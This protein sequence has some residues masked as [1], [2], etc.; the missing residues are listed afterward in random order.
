M[1]N[2]NLFRKLNNFSTGFSIV[3]IVGFIFTFVSHFYSL[4]QGTTFI[5][6]IVDANFYS[7]IAFFIMLFFIIVW[8]AYRTFLF[9][10]SRI[11]PDIKIEKL[12]IGNRAF[13]TI[14]NNETVAIENISVKIAD[15]RYNN[16]PNDVE[17]FSKSKSFSTGLTDIGRKIIPN[18]SPINVLIAQGLSFKYTE[19]FIDD[20]NHRHIQDLRS[21]ENSSWNKYEMVF[22]IYGQ[23]ADEKENRLL[24]IYKGI[25]THINHFPQKDGQVIMDNLVWETFEKNTIKG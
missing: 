22:H 20:E 24:G 18:S 5:G 19:F 4:P 1:L 2:H 21:N 15:F 3:S 6:A 9:Y 8:I 14:Q 17:N 11:E 25:L 13:I 10:L 23:L 16:S 7:S 12:H